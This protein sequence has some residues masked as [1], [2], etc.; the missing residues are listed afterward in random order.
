M[1]GYSIIYSSEVAHHKI[2][3]SEK[4]VESGEFQEK[5][6]NV[7]GS[8]FTKFLN[9]AK[10]NSITFEKRWI[11]R[12]LDYKEA[13]GF[14]AKAEAVLNGAGL[15]AFFV[16]DISDDQIK[17]LK[18]ER[19]F[20]RSLCKAQS[21]FNRLIQIK[22]INDYQPAAE[23]FEEL[24]AH[25]HNNEDNLLK[26]HEILNREVGRDVSNTLLEFCVDFELRQ[27]GD[28]KL[29]LASFVESNA[30]MA[31]LAQKVEKGYRGSIT[32]N[33]NL[34][35]TTYLIPQDEKQQG[36]FMSLA[37]GYRKIMSSSTERDTLLK[38]HNIVQSSLKDQN[39]QNIQLE[40][41]KQKNN[42]DIINLFSHPKEDQN[43]PEIEGLSQ[44]EIRSIN[45]LGKSL[46]STSVETLEI[47]MQEAQ[48]KL[49]KATENGNEWKNKTEKI[50]FLQANEMKNKNSDGFPVSINSSLEEWNNS[51]DAHNKELEK[52][53]NE[54][55]DE[56]GK[57]KTKITELNDE[58]KQ[59]KENYNKSLGEMNEIEKSLS[60]LT[61]QVREAALK[62]TK[63]E[64]AE[65]Y[66]EAL[67]AKTKKSQEV[68][69]IKS[70]ISK[71]VQEKE[72]LD[73]EYKKF[74]KNNEINQ[75]K[76]QLSIDNIE[77]ETTS[78][79]R[80]EFYSWLLSTDLE[81]DQNTNLNRLS[82]LK[83]QATKLE[84]SIAKAKGEL[85]TATQE[86]NT[87][88]DDIARLKDK[89]L[90]FSNENKLTQVDWKYKNEFINEKTF[91]L[92]NNQNN[93]LKIL[94]NL[95]YISLK[96]TER[97]SFD[98]MLNMIRDQ[99]HLQQETSG[100]EEVD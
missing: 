15:G 70:S 26:I 53:N 10:D 96:D 84:A 82:E 39:T 98:L 75:K 45:K 1:S 19:D 22:D 95:Y 18:Q 85:K 79:N 5:S 33:E 6:T 94:N 51:L 11:Y 4:Q 43:L 90:T 89:G 9:D 14:F 76:I 48:K 74:C 65:P 12:Y 21:A 52:L 91:S 27:N 73:R 71:K 30:F 34:I 54:L 2:F 64:N 17:L 36:V 57:F 56:E 61:E 29:A 67:E 28:M 58:I 24:C 32:A 63:I 31:K 62:E 77:K 66:N 8:T 86:L 25:A 41:F 13:T 97:L 7:E 99:I 92:K 37:R 35:Y 3:S 78:V 68:S 60:P 59:L 23:A 38:V 55:I 44:E 100:K 83:K 42:R 46:Q 16:G 80:E 50:T 69:E 72:N 88:K 20:Y 49:D 47:K 40:A 87:L 93:T 81:E